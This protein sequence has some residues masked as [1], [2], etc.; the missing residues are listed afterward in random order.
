MAFREYP[1]MK[2]TLRLG[3]RWSSSSANCRPF[4]PG[5]TMSVKSRSIRNGSQC[6]RDRAIRS[7][8]DPIVQILQ[9]FHQI[10]SH[11][12]FILDHENGFTSKAADHRHVDLPGDVG[13]DMGTRQIDLYRRPFADLAVD[14]DVTSGLFDE[15]ID[16]AQAKASAMPRLLGREKR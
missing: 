9:R 7:L 13:A 12:G 2:S 16:L 4:I 5:I 1:V 11:V 3:C 14:F 15:A 8:A 6:K 10:G